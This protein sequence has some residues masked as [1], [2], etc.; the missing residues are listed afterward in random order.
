MTDLFGV[1]VPSF[2]VRL[3]HKVCAKLHTSLGGVATCTACLGGL[4]SR[5]LRFPGFARLPVGRADHRRNARIDLRV[6]LGL[7][8]FTN[9]NGGAQ[10]SQQYGCTRVLGPEPGYSAPQD[11]PPWTARPLRGASRL[12]WARSL[13]HLAVPQL[14]RRSPE[15]T[16]TSRSDLADIDERVVHRY[17]RHRGGKQSHPAW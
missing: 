11:R 8:G 13:R 5:S 4:N 9:M 6:Q 7:L 16:A 17:L 10:L 1:C 14:G 3:A 12:R 15:W 2:S